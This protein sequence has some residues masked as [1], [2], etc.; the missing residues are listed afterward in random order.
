MKLQFSPGHPH[1][2]REDRIVML[3]KKLKQKFPE[4]FSGPRFTDP[5]SL[6]NGGI[7]TF[8]DDV[9]HEISPYSASRVFE[10]PDI[11]LIRWGCN[12]MRWTASVLKELDAAGLIY[13]IPFNESFKYSAHYNPERNGEFFSALEITYKFYHRVWQISHAELQEKATELISGNAQESFQKERL[14]QYSLNLIM[15][16]NSYLYTFHNDTSV[17]I[18]G[19]QEKSR[20]VLKTNF[21]YMDAP[22]GLCLS[23][24][25]KPDA[26]IAFWP[27]S[28]STILI[29]QIQGISKKLRN[30]HI[31]RSHA[32][33]L[34]D[35]NW[36]SIMIGAADWIAGMAGMRMGI[37][38]AKNNKWI[39][40][41]S[42]GRFHLPYD[43]AVQKYDKVAK[44][45]GMQQSE[46]GN[47][48]QK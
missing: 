14:S 13:E 10:I 45:H 20:D 2:S 3:A 26:V 17:I 19:K 29:H 9:C 24:R 48:Y 47:Y 12:D 35:L 15:L 18:G 1:I 43:L 6:R 39:K 22:L 34:I 21:I 41:E 11:S 33:G 7:F 27:E 5:E 30:M 28:E 44:M 37:L 16:E 8:C 25:Q 42:T 23:Y 46:N 36:R 38:G 32:R 40:P 31:V 4:K